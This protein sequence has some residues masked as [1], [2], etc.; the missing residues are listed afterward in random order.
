MYARAFQNCVLECL[1]QANTPH[2]KSLVLRG[3]WLCHLLLNVQCRMLAL[4]DMEKEPEREQ[5]QRHTNKSA[6][7]QRQECGRWTGCIA[8]CHSNRDQVGK[9][10]Q[11]P[12]SKNEGR[13]GKG[14]KTDQ[15][16]A[17]Q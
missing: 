10:R 16:V 12:G 3:C 6:N 9:L 2:R 14:Q 1:P 11:A 4:E 17:P 7:K 8:Y 15:A 13:Y 5:E